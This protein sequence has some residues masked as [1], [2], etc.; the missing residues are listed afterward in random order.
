MKRT[1]GWQV[2]VREVRVDPEAI[3][4]LLS[5]MKDCGAHCER[6]PLRCGTLLTTAGARQ[7]RACFR[8]RSISKNKST[9]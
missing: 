9:S 8:P 4:A 3:K 2:L 7:K 1:K 6:L 5:K